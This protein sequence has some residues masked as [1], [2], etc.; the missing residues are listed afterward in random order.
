M[1]TYHSVRL[2]KNTLDHSLVDAIQET[3]HIF[4]E[5]KHYAYSLLL[6]Q[7]R[8]GVSYDMSIHMMV[9]TVFGLNDYYAN[10]ALGEA[11]GVLE[12]QM[13]LRT[14]YL[15]DSDRKIK[16]KEA[17]LKK[18]KKRR[19][20]SLKMLESLIKGKY[21]GYQGCNVTYDKGLDLY[22]IGNKK[23]KYSRLFF[24]SYDFEHKYLRPLIKRLK[25][26]IGNIKHSIH[27]VKVRKASKESRLSGAC[28]GS[29]K[30]FKAQFTKE[31]YQ[32]NHSKWYEDFHR[33]RHSKMR[34]SGR[35]DGK[36]GNF[37]FKY[38]H[39][40]ETLSI[41][42]GG[43]K[44]Y[45]LNGIHFPYGQDVINEVFA[46]HLNKKRRSANAWEIEDHGSYYIIKV[47]IKPIIDKTAINYSKAEGCIGIDL[48]YD[49]FAWAELNG[50]GNLIDKGTIRFSLHGLSKEQA[51]KV[52]E[53][54]AL[55]LV[56]LAVE[57]KKPIVREV[58]DL[59]VKK[60]QMQY[61]SKK[62]N[63]KVS[64][65]A[66]EKM[67][68]AIDSRTLK[69]AV[70]VFKVNPAYTSVIGK[71]KYM[72]SLGL[73]IHQSA[74]YVIGRRGMRLK[75]KIP[76]AY[77]E[78]LTDKKKVRHHWSQWNYIH[79]LTKDYRPNVFYGLEKEI[80]FSDKKALKQA[81]EKLA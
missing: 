8:E 22:L 62:G 79:R 73:S 14:L 25:V 72:K 46:A 19:M 47:M 56:E 2:Y 3:L 78:V 53:A 60:S 76:K 37:A 41:N 20:R 64:H 51:G 55:K 74:S 35:K 38:D 6:Y 26:V 63:R 28:F 40:D 24:S 10:S 4:N 18:L 65:F 58:L 48:G 75:E 80:S 45:S 30:L 32:A 50:E 71:I 33:R 49:H 39:L 31:S 67:C 66:Y 69:M 81:L 7:E 54:K 21:K 59:S 11:K 57:R 61:E 36:Y 44:T 42:L 68:S 13:A 9:K 16:K 29:K 70:G 5:A 1:R 23:K 52:I 77:F 34:I 17:K 43:G 15:G 27:I 12:S